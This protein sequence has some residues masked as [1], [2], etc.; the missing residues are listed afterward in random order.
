MDKLF[1]IYDDVRGFGMCRNQADF[2]RDWL[3]RSDCYLSYVRSSGAKPSLASIGF[4]A[5]KLKAEAECAKAAD[6]LVFYRKIRSTCVS[7]QT[8]YNALYELKYVPPF[9]RVTVA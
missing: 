4:L 9:Y 7:A 8:L 2:S 1:E 3:G 6:E 5:Q